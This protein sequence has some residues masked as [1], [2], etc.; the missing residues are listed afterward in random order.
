MG[1]LWRTCGAQRTTCGSW[2]CA[3]TYRFQGLRSGQQAQWQD[4]LCTEPSHQPKVLVLKYFSLH[5]NMLARKNTLNI[6]HKGKNTNNQQIFVEFHCQLGIIEKQDK[7]ALRFH[8]S[9]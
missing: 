5:K 9:Q 7:T 2:L 1:V 8:L 6:V 3:S 4:L